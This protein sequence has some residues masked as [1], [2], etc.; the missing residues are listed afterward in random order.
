[1]ARVPVLFLAAGSTA[2]LGKAFPQELVKEMT[3]IL[4]FVIPDI[5][6]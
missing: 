6:R 1:M 5:F 4:L 2:E 3:K